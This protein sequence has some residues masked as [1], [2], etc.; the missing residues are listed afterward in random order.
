MILW[1]SK[2]K[3]ESI[4]S[5]ETVDL[6]LPAFLTVHE[7]GFAVARVNPRWIK[8]FGETQGQYA[9]TDPSDARI[10]A[11]YGVTMNPDPWTHYSEDMQSFKDL[12]S[13]SRQLTMRRTIE[14]NRSQQTSNAYMFS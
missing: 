8:N 12:S 3:A 11:A 4:V 10:I 1:F 14:K 7:E 5:E 6:E 2:K 9:K 13:R